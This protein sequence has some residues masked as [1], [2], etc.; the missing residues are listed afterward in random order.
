MLSDKALAIASS[1][2][3]FCTVAA[4]VQLIHLSKTSRYLTVGC[5]L[6]NEAVPSFSVRT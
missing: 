2:Q 3:C 1:M 5:E 4:H 6:Q